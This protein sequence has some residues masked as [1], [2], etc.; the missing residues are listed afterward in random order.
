MDNFEIIYKILHELKEN[1]GNEKFN[2]YTISCKELKISFPKWEY[3]LIALQDE[4]YIRGLDIS[5]IPENKTRYIT[6]ASGIGITIKGLEYLEEN[7]LMLK[8]AKRY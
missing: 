2:I 4:G 6:D 8:A 3:L 7:I 5:D 1:M